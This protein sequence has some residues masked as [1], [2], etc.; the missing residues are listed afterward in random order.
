MMKVVGI[1]VVTL[2]ACN[3]GSPSGPDA[4]APD[5]S[6]DATLDTSLDAPVADTGA[7]APGTDGGHVICHAD[8]PYL[9]TTG[10]ASGYS[11][12]P[13][14]G[15]WP[16]KR[17]SDAQ[18]AEL[19]KEWQAGDISAFQSNP[20]N[21]TCLSC[22]V[23]TIDVDA[24]APSASGV[25]VRTHGE[26]KPVV[27]VGGCIAH[28]DG[29][30]SQTGCGAL[31]QEV[32]DCLTYECGDCADFNEYCTNQGSNAAACSQHALSGG[33]PCGFGGGCFLELVDGGVAQSCNA[34]YAG[35]DITSLSAQECGGLPAD[36]GAD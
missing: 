12:V 6:A 34:A 7:D 5:A 26:S 10:T 28:F 11:W 31:T 29:D 18:L 15:P 33:G 17:C 13:P 27:N 35:C 20:S 32:F 36:A 4:A 16:Q 14:V 9:G 21:A 30:N 3:Q 22:L 8:R 19:D 25:L 24:A 2:L 23:T 1:L